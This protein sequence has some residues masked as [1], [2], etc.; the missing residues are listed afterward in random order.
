VRLY[1]TYYYKNWNKYTAKIHSISTRIVRKLRILVQDGIGEY[2]LSTFTVIHKYSIQE[3]YSCIIHYSEQRKETEESCKLHGDNY[4]TP[5]RLRKIRKRDDGPLAGY[6]SQNNA[7]RSRKE[8]RL[9]CLFFVVILL[10]MKNI[11]F[12]ILQ[13]YHCILWSSYL[14]LL[15]HYPYK[16]ARAASSGSPGHSAMEPAA[17]LTLPYKPYGKGLNITKC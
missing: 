14:A 12:R 16:H 5:Q 1:Y 17:A 15:L 10:S 9:L 13:Y 8:G 7:N 2:T 11:V 6:R 4:G 3:I